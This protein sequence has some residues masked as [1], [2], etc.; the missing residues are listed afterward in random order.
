[1]A[2]L[3]RKG[4]TD[5]DD[6][7]T[8]SEN[9]PV[10]PNAPHRVPAQRTTPD[11]RRTPSVR[12]RAEEACNPPIDAHPFTAQRVTRNTRRRMNVAASVL[13]IRGSEGKSCPCKMN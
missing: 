6:T 8:R 5:R 2:T 12:G 9:P 13:P 7:A 3:E 1:M 4:F 11:P 10:R